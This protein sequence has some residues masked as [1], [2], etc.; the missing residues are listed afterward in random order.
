MRRSRRLVLSFIATVGNYEYGFFWYF[1][2]DGTIQFESK[3][4]GCLSTGALAPGAA[5]PAYGALVAPQLYAP[6]HQ[7]FFNVRLDMCVDGPDNTVQEINTEAVPP[8]P[9]N[10]H[11]NAFVH[12]AVSFTRES[13]AVRRVCLEYGPVLED[14]QPRRQ[15]SPGRPGRLQAGSRRELPAFRTRRVRA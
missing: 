15:E 8:G 10:P 2:Q 11:D 4:T 6:S 14:H 7:H 3:L 5:T 9:D 12:K 1:Y 13:E